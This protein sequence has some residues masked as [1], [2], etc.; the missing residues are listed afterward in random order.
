M[1]QPLDRHPPIPPTRCNP[2]LAAPSRDWNIFQQLLAAHWDGCTHAHPRYQTS[3]D[4]DLVATMLACGNPDKRGSLA[5]RCRHGGQGTHR[6]AMRCTS[7]LCLRCA[8]V[9][10]DNWVSQGSQVLHAGGSYRPIILTV[11]AM[12]RT[13][14]YHHAVLLL[15]A[16]MRCG[17]QC[18]EDGSRAVRGQALRGGYLAVLHTHG[19]HGQYPPPLPLLATSGG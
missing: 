10:V 4:N 16:L 5:Y 17:V 3:S 15:R 11:P 13:P 19:R 12:L 8:K 18:L 6:G 1:V 14:F 7:S 9:D 2:M